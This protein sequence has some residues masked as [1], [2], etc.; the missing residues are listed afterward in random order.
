MKRL[1]AF[2]MAFLAALSA[3]SAA[4]QTFDGGGQVT[5]NWTTGAPTNPVGAAPADAIEPAD[6]SDVG[7]DEED[8]IIETDGTVDYITTVG[9][10]RK[11][12]FLCEPDE[13]AILDPIVYYGQAAPVGHAHQFTGATATPTS[14]FTSNRAD[15]SSTCAG[16]PLFATRYWEPEMFKVMPNGL[17]VGVRHDKD[18]FYYV[19]G[20]IGD[21]M[22]LTWIRR[23]FAFI[24]GANPADYNDTALRAEY[25]AAGLLYPGSPDTP[26]G[27]GV[28]GWQ[29]YAGS[30]P[31]VA[32]TV[33]ETAS[34][35]KTMKGVVNTAAARHLSNEN[36]DDPWG[37]N[38]TGTE[39]E[40]GILILNLDAPTCWD[41]T[42]LRGGPTG[43]GHVRHAGTSADDARVRECPDAWGYVPGLVTKKEYR[44]T[45]FAD[46]GTWFLSSDRMHMAT[47]ECP[48]A[49]APCDGVSGGNVPATVGGVAYTRVSLDPCRAV[50]IDFCPGST[51]HFDW[52]YGAKGAIFDE[53]QRECLGIT[54][55][56]VAPTD[57]PGECNTSQI[58]K[59]RKMK[60]GGA[61]PDP[62]MSGGCVTINA[63]HSALPGNV[64]RYNPLPAGTTADIEVVHH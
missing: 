16:G 21:P 29:C 34:R 48:D 52:I 18:T 53:M 8:W 3:Q 62:T 23:N 41:R 9:A 44:H 38:C 54:V 51:G 14:T 28:S 58:S 7:F 59:F 43:R 37:G 12:R 60:Y 24:A 64:E 19:E 4:A 10:E 63:C 35:M 31:T 15:P 47:T 42:N 6:A 13:V 2:L 33:T 11:S 39:A 5:P 55:R 45:G 26:A 32:V 22:H 20:L 27:F 50:S 36:G 25:A 1:A 30:A 61:S 46:Y 57:G 56:G 40:P 49:A 17:I